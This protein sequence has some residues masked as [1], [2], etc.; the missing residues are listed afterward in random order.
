MNLILVLALCAYVAHENYLA[1]SDQLHDITYSFVFAV[2]LCAAPFL[3]VA[4]CTATQEVANLGG[5]FGVLVLAQA[6]GMWWFLDFA[7]LLQDP[8]SEDPMIQ[9]D[10]KIKNTLKTIAYGHVYAV[11]AVSHAVRA[12]SAAA[13]CGGY[14]VL[15]LS[16]PD[17]VPAKIAAAPNGVPLLRVET[18]A[19]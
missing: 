13:A 2:E 6:V 1:V 7:A 19:V 16:R 9:H 15:R 18:F 14:A 4:A 8:N 5:A 17:A 12:L 3:V 11:F 10:I